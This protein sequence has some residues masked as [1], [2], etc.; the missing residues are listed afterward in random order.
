MATKVLLADDHQIIREGLHHLLDHQPDIEVVGEASNGHEAVR[1]AEETQPDVVIMDVGMPQLNGIEATRQIKSKNNRIKVV[2]LSVHSDHRFITKTLA[3][4]ATGYLLKDSAVDDVVAAIHAVMAGKSYLS[5][6]IVDTVV[7]DY[8]DH[9]TQ[10]RP[11]PAPELTA[12]EREVLQLLAEGHSTRE[13]AEIISVSTKTVDTHR[14]NIMI[15]LDIYSIAELTKYALR[16]G[17]VSL[18]E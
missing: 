1:L 11:A 5:P 16:E 10:A 9:V 13:V 18:S 2:A 8:V 3:A 12:R 15:K 14:R 7:T 6:E 17:L 4:G